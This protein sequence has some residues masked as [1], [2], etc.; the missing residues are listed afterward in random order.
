MEERRLRIF[1]DSNVILSGLFSDKGPP[2]VIL[3]L[4]C[5][6]L[7]MLAGLTGRY[8]LMEIER[9]LNKK[10][11]EALPVYHKYFSAL[12]LEIIPL[13]LPKEIKKL[14]GVIAEKDIPV[15][16]S[17]ING[18]ADFL[19]TGDKKDFAKLKAKS[20]YEF[21]IASPAEFLEEIVP[22]ILKK[23]EG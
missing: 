23:I 13:P 14:A 9:N 20:V 1:L 19:V 12:D 8:N 22:E 11:P 10:L 15:L 21:K 5:I 16:I 7:P 4:L 18:K 2:R 3:D 6:G 17:A